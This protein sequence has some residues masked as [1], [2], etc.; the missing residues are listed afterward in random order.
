MERYKVVKGSQSCHCC[1]EATVVDTTKPLEQYP[2][3][4]GLPEF[5]SVC[6]CMDMESAELVC[7]A[8]NSVEDDYNE[9]TTV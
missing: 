6:E 2:G 9:S 3:M 4:Q 7:D 5:D 1:F 8:L